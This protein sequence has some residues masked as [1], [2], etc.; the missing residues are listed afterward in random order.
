MKMNIL[1]LI[2]KGITGPKPMECNGFLNI[3]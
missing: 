2:S 1:K 3:F